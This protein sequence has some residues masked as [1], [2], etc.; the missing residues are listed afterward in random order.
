LQKFKL[1]EWD[2]QDER[3]AFMLWSDAC[4]T[5]L[6]LHGWPGGPASLLRLIRETRLQLGQESPPE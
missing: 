1:A 6:G 4:K 2:T 3:E 5:F